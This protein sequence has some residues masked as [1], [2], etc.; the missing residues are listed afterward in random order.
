MDHPL[1]K[2]GPAEGNRAFC[3]KMDLLELGIL[4]LDVTSNLEL[5]IVEVSRSSVQLLFGQTRFE[6]PLEKLNFHLEVVLNFILDDQFEG[7]RGHYS[8]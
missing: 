4:C 2:E 6:N 5:V 1:N 8:Q 7:R 3:N